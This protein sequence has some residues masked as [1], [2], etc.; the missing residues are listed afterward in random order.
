MFKKCYF[1]FD[2]EFRF[3]L[4]PILIKQSD[5]LYSCI[6]LLEKVALVRRMRYVSR[7]SPNESCLLKQFY[8]GIE[9]I[10]LFYQYWK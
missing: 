7:S 10:T 9:S 2:I 4:L 3:S 5:R 6:E 1:R 8:A